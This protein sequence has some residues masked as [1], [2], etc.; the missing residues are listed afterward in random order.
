MDR[1]R[2]RFA[3]IQLDLYLDKLLTI[4]FFFLGNLKFVLLSGIKKT[5]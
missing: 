3:E 2:A 5:V 1:T 4:D